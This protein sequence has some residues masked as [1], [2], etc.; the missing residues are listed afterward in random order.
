[1]SPQLPSRLFRVGPVLVGLFLG[2][3]AGLNAALTNRWSFSNA[4]GA[5]PA[6]TVVTDSIS[7]QSA[8]IRG[9][10][11]SFAAGAL[12][13]PGNTTGNQT[14]AAV[15]AYVDLPNGIISSKTSLSIELWAT[16]LS[17]QAYQRL[18][19]LGR[20]VQAGDGLGAAGE[21]TGT[22]T[23]APGATQASDGLTLTMSRG[24]SLNEQRFEGKL[25]GAANIPD[26]TG[27]YRLADTNLATMAGVSYHYV[28]TF[29]GGA[30]S[31]G[32]GG[33][34]LSWYRNG[35]LSATHDVGFQL[36]QIEDVNNWLGRSLWSAD[37]C[38]NASYDEVRVYNH[39]QSLTEIQASR[40]LGP[41]PTLPIA[42]GDS[43]T[44][45]RNQKASIPVL[46]NDTGG[47][48]IKL[49]SAPQY[50]TAVV[51]SQGRVLYSHTSGSPAVDSFTY[52][53]V[54][55]AG[56]SA[57][58]T[59]TVNFSGNL[60][61]ATPG[62]NVPSVPPPT[63]YEIVDAFGTLA[64]TDPVCLATPPGEAQ[65]LF[66]CQK[67]G[68][69]RIIPNVLAA[70][71]TATTFL[72][73]PALLASRGETISTSGEQGLIG[74]AFHP[75][76]ATNGYFFIFYSVK[77][78]TTTYE[79][80]SRFK[81]QSGNAAAADPASERVL[82]EQVD[83]YDNHNGS[84]LQFGADGYLYV[85]VGDEGNQNDAGANSQKI[86]KDFFSGILRLDV[87]K[88]PGNLEPNAHPNPTES[89]PAVNAVKRYETSP[90]SGVFLAAYSVPTDN[91]WVHTNQGGTWTGSFNGSAIP[92]ASLP[93]VRSEFWAVGLRN[94][95]RMAF[96]PPTGELWVGD[97]GS[98][99]R[100][101]VDVVSKGQN[102]GWA[103][104]EGTIAGPKAGAPANFATLYATAPVYDYPHGTGTLQ[105]N[106]ITGGFVYRGSRFASLTGAYIFADYV[107]GNL[108]TLRR[109]GA[110]APTVERIAGEGG[111][112]AFGQDPSNGDVLMAN[113][114]SDKIRRL[115]SGTPSNAFPISLSATGLFASLTDLSPNPGVLPYTVNLPFWSDHA[116]KRRWFTIPDGVAQMGWTREGAWTFPAGQ[117]WVKHFDLPL[118]RSNPPQPGDASTPS[119]RIETRL[120]V[121]NGSGAYGVS[122]RW[123]DAGTEATLVPDEGVDFDLNLTQ[124][125]SPYTQRWHIPSRGECLLCHTPQGGHAL[126]MN[127]RQ[128]NLSNTINGFTGNQI[129]LL[130]QSGYFSNTPEP[131]NVL[132]RHLKQSET[133]FPLEARVRSWMDVNCSYC[134]QA[135]GTAGTAAWDGRSSLTLA[136]TGVLLGNASNNGGDPL[137][138]LIVPGDAAHSI[139]LNRTAASN[140]FTRMPPVGSNELDQTSINLLTQWIQQTL[141][142]RQTYESWRQTQ[143]GNLPAAQSDPAADPDGDGKTNQEEFLAG[144]APLNSASF[145]FIQTG[146]TNSEFRMDF[147]LPAN[148]SLQVETSS[149]MTDWMLWNVPG[150]HG[151]PH[152]GGPL[153]LQGSTDNRSFFRVNLKEN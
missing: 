38:A 131:P 124:N 20:V 98:D 82:L 148:R 88:K 57:L 105:G 22:A 119:K 58:A 89:T 13:L 151:I 43:V 74:L 117:I 81:V 114:S 147:S 60:R 90:G 6:G 32:T 77:M 111:I 55:A 145:P 2:S 65:R 79:R 96:D 134:H 93:Y 108:W 86:T 135:G 78:G 118:S 9:Q 146:I 103:Y 33:G 53:A 141:P 19:D 64:F 25:N 120:L 76:Y 87:D 110:A 16:P 97:V 48:T 46:A 153:M 23:T 66:V 140:G 3:A 18:I 94:P 137:N 49:V 24:A 69:L 14:P 104:R 11:A 113:L 125:G 73:L 91:P 144:T 54:N 44:M 149:N 40:A 70:T 142:A 101:E 106:S 21:I 51:D 127:S 12:T 17:F 68:L 1:M 150:N 7:G 102:L 109:N 121:K 116:I 143:F 72:D 52:R 75:A 36:N 5:A 37:R 31:F 115:V 62:L 10:G 123:N 35:V 8:I 85:S 99:T 122:Y 34:R 71:P 92:A 15:S 126:S 56:E 26:P 4:A 80:L 50:G 28:I 129:N 139:I 59:V 61:L 152:P 45:H 130:Q 63:N 67:G 100:E 39:A 41:N 27:L 138:K 136:Q 107:S 30:G 47:V 95:W 133:A 42:A 132:P 112:A 84:A 128:L 29:E 83:D